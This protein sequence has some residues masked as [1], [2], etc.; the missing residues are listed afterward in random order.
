MFYEIVLVLVVDI[1]LLV[2]APSTSL[3]RGDIFV[4]HQLRQKVSNFLL[5]V[6]LMEPHRVFQR[7]TPRPA[8][9]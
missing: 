6:H 7:L 4:I 2:I 9:N 5:S 1:N 8:P 3:E